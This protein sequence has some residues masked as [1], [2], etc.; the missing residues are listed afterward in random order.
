[1]GEWLGPPHEEI[2]RCGARTRLGHPCGHFA[3]SNGRCR[4]HGGKSAGAR[5][6]HRAIKHGLCTKEAIANN[7]FLR[8]LLR[9]SNQ[10]IA[11]VERHIAQGL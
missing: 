8:E 7:R 10:T 5:N 6:P 2:P 4:Y 9:D 11:D 3:M 1:M